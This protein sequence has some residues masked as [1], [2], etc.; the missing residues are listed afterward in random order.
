KHRSH[1]PRAVAA[2]VSGEKEKNPEP[3]LILIKMRYAVQVDSVG[4]KPL[5]IDHEQHV[6]HPRRQ[7]HGH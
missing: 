6:F 2:S 1:I 3:A 4:I 5:R 7:H